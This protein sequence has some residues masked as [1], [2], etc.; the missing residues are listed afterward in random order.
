MIYNKNGESVLNIKT[1]QQ[2]YIKVCYTFD[3]NAI[4]HNELTRNTFSVMG[5]SYSTYDGYTNVG[6]RSGYTTWYPANDQSFTDVSQTWWKL[7][8]S[9]TGL[10]LLDIDAY[11]GTCICYDGY[12]DGTKDQGRSG[13]SFVQRV[14]MVGYAEY[15][16][17]FGATNDS[18]VNVG[19]GNYVY[20]NWTE[21]DKEFFRPACAYLLYK[22]KKIYPLSKIVFIKNT[23]LT[24]GIDESI[25]TICE[26][27]S[28]PVIELQD[29]EKNSG[30]PTRTGMTQ[31][32]TQVKAFID[33][34]Q[35]S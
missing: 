28:V 21:F 18:T 33:S 10:S 24:Q 12:G 5:D 13:R 4:Y 15:I 16:F 30:H 23:G 2:K 8:E 7:L 22:L 6:E 32:A 11:S 34:Y 1:L 35:F 17:I 25:D 3:N 31:I 19:L 14:D 29:I 20:S 26:H 9:E 27:Y